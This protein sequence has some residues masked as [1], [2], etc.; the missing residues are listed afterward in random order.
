M[1]FIA[2]NLEVN[3]KYILSIGLN[4]CWRALGNK[5]IYTDI[6]EIDIILNDQTNLGIDYLSKIIKSKTWEIEHDLLTIISTN[7]EYEY[8]NFT[9]NNHRNKMVE[10]LNS[11]IIM[12]K[13]T[14]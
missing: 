4:M 10:I 1:E 12:D 5:F 7:T 6:S 8:M 3:D 2:I 9:Q 14:K 11:I 13:L